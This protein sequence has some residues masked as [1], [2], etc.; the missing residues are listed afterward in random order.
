[1]KIASLMTDAKLEAEGRE[2]SMGDGG[3]VTVARMGNPAYKTLYRKLIRP[4][5]QQVKDEVLGD[6]VANSVYIAVLAQ[7]VL[8]NWRGIKDVDGSEPPYSV[9]KATEW[10]TIATEFR[11]RVIG[12]ANDFR[13][14]QSA[15]L[16][17]DEGALGNGSA[18]TSTGVPSSPT[19]GSNI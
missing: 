1:M 9:A 18:G 15:S 6:E 8:L 2:F 10:L 13:N 5:K 7:T 17:E 14:F 3:F 19:T 16:T 11:D 4:Y 12:F